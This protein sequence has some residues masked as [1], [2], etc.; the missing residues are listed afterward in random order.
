[1]T[2]ADV[3]GDNNDG[4]DEDQEGIEVDNDAFPELETEQSCLNASID[5]D[6]DVYHGMD[7][8]VQQND[9]VK[10]GNNNSDVPCGIGANTQSS[11]SDY[12]NQIL[13][14]FFS[15]L[16]IKR[17]QGIHCQGSS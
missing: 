7:Q 17:W 1:V 10:D 5:N 16:F 6:I 2:S 15:M 8:D 4:D 14:A 13:I 3:T 12:A 9:G 11:P